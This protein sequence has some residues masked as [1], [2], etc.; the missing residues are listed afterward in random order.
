MG[1][2]RT[3]EQQA[4]V[5]K[6]DAA[7]KDAEKELKKLS[8]ANVKPVAEWMKA[9]FTKAGYKRLCR[10]LVATVSDKP[11]KKVDDAEAES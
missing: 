11:A 3:A 5:D 10:L 6:M 7:A 2:E 4:I 8:K 1:K 9:N